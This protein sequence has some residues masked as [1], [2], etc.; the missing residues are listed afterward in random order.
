[1]K[2]F[3]T[4]VGCELGD[5]VDPAGGGQV[6]SDPTL[7][8][9]GLDANYAPLGD[10]LWAAFGGRLG[11]TG[12]AVSYV[13]PTGVDGNPLNYE[14]GVLVAALEAIAAHLG[15]IPAGDLIADGPQGLAA[16]A[17]ATWS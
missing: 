1:M 4:S 3:G 10:Q 12:V 16:N 14:D 13:A 6:W 17:T 15:L 11:Q 7:V 2:V 9:I 5:V 8:G